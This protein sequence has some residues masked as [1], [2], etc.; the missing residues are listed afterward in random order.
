MINTSVGAQMDG[1]KYSC[2]LN[3][4]A[5]GWEND[6]CATAQKQRHLCCAYHCFVLGVILDLELHTFKA[7]EY[8]IQ[9][10]SPPLFQQNS[11]KSR[12]TQ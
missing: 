5:A 10:K 1:N 9:E 4:V 12:V 11:A 6:S 3:N 8:K 2:Y 7:P